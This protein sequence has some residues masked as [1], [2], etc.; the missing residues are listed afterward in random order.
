MTDLAAF[1]LWVLLVLVT[2]GPTN[3]LL[4]LGGTLDGPKALRLVVAE[5]AGYLISIGSLTFLIL[6]IPRMAEALPLLRFLCGLFII[7][8]AVRSWRKPDLDGHA[9]AASVSFPEVFVTTILNPKGLIFAIQIFPDGGVIGFGDTLPYF[10]VF[11]LTCLA[12]GS[13][14]TLLGCLV[15]AQLVA[16]AATRRSR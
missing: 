11:A 1:A 3:T 9:G 7:G 4:A 5:L 6:T 16:S 2:P 15:R 13:L 14:W 12:V 10:G 8:L